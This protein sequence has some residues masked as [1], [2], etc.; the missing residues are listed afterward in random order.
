MRVSVTLCRFF[1]GV[2]TRLSASF[3]SGLCSRGSGGGRQKGFTWLGVP[4]AW[5][6]EL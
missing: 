3:C 5:F 4:R 1:F 6:I 2:T